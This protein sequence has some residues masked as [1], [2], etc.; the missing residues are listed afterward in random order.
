MSLDLQQVLQQVDRL[1]QEAAR[2]AGEVAER[3]P[4]ADR[5]LDQAA[6]LDPAELRR[7]IASAPD[8]LRPARPTDEPV[9][10]RHAC[11]SHP[12]RLRL[13]A[14]D[15]SQVYPDRHAAAMFFLINVGSIALDHG[16][17]EPPTVEVRSRLHS[18]EEELHDSRGHPVDTHLVNARR[19][20]CELEA[21]AASA[22]RPTPGPTVAL[23]DNGLLLWAASQEQ[24]A[25]RP[26]VQRLLEDY[27]GSLDR[28]R[29]AGVALAGYISRPRNTHVV[30][31][32]EA[33]AGTPRALH[34]LTDRLV[35]GRR[36]SAG[37]RSARFIHP[38]K[39]N[40]VFTGRGHQVQ[41]F[42]LHTGAQDGIARIEI[43]AWVGEEAKRLEALQAA[44][45]EQCRP[46]GV[47]YLLV[48]AHELALVGQ[49]D[50]RTLDGLIQS[51]LARH[52]IAG[53]TSQKAQTKRWTARRRRHRV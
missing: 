48:R 12:P 5:L 14:A 44:V 45:V 22:E 11:P 26:D 18:G 27:L 51:T 3:L 40:D 28:L 25:S 49:D 42:Y 39:I 17:G 13:L 2:R 8:G 1:G 35:F 47:P 9:G 20:A 32:A 52:G 46:T 29:D 24:N 31:L 33:V 41:F 7:R 16:S 43:P 30:D 36:L 23:L 21:L 50:R 19:D 37:E 10:A 38:A 6:A 4:L 53:L 34:G 15:G